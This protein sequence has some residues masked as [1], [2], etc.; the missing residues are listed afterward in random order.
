ME[1]LLDCG[2]EGMGR[3]HN[4][5]AEMDGNGASDQFVMVGGHLDSWD[6]GTG[7][8]DNAA[9]VA[10][11]MAAAKLAG[12]MPGRP[13]RGIRVVLFANEEQGIYGGK[14]YAAQ[15]A[16]QLQRHAIG[17]ESDLGAGRVYA[18]RSRVAPSAMPAVARL[19]QW[20]APLEVPYQ[21]D[22]QATGGADLGQMRQLGMPMVD[23]RLDATNY[24]DYHHNAN[25]TLDK[26]D[27]AALAHNVAAFST[28]IYWATRVDVDFGPLAP[29]D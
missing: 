29:S 7:A 28:F 12:A 20:L 21:P 13:G 9:G 15:H 27:P 5:I 1:L 10:T 19:E 4:V 3:S 26:I 11:T 14:A 24:F 6:L 23:L 18:F 2:Y 22:R 8:H 16:A 17:A 25:D